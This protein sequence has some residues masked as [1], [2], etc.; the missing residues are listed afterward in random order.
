[1][2]ALIT[3]FDEEHKKNFALMKSQRDAI[4]YLIDVSME[5]DDEDEEDYAMDCCEGESAYY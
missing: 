2:Q 3:E 4:N 5:G 1:M